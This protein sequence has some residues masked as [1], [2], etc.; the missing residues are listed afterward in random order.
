MCVLSY[1]IHTQYHSLLHP[2]PKIQCSVQTLQKNCPMQFQ[3][4]YT[5]HTY[6]Y[7]ILLMYSF[8]VV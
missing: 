7:I 1:D 8:S 5:Y 3:I 6:V 4:I 2:L